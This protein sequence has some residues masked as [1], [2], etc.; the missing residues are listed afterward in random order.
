MVFW[1]ATS[2]EIMGAIIESFQQVSKLCF[3]EQ[4]EILVGG[5]HSG[6]IKVN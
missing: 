5:F 6:E 2:G 4:E 3:Y 1:D